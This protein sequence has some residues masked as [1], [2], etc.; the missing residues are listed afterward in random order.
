MSEVSQVGF[1]N[2]IWI[3]A[4][5]VLFSRSS[6]KR[7]YSVEFTKKQEDK[8]N[9]QENQLIKAQ[10]LGHV[11]HVIPQKVCRYNL[12]FLKVLW[13]QDQV[14]PEQAFG[15]VWE[16]FYKKVRLIS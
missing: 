10:E 16:H 3:K 14:I 4:K 13:K 6:Q 15:N 12:N 7:R 5:K 8:Q 2:C 11:S 1:L 9:N